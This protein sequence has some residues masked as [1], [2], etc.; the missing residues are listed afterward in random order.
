LRDII[1][2]L[3]SRKDAGGAKFS[4]FVFTQ[5]RWWRKV[6][7]FC[8]HAKTLVTQRRKDAKFSIFIFTLVMQSFNYCIKISS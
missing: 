4:L 7:S 8:F 2:F 5:R 1:F 6:F 3:F